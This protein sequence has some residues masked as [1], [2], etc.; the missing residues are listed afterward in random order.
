MEAPLT[1]IIVI[2]GPTASG[3]SGL[4]LLAAQ[5]LKGVIVNADS[6]Q[7]YQGMDIG[8]AK[9]SAAER[10]LAEHRLFDVAAPDEDFDAAR[11][12]ALAADAIK[13]IT[14]RGKL[15][16]VTGG[17]GLYIRA[18]LHGLC[19]APEIPATV[20]EKYRRL[21]N[22]EGAPALHALLAAKDPLMASRLHVNDYVRVSRALEVWEVAGESLAAWQARHGGFGALRYNTLQI[23]VK[24]NREELYARINLRV[25]NM[26]ARGF[27][28][29]VRGLLAKGYHAGLKSMGSIGYKQMAAYIAGQMDYAEMTRLMQ[30]D[31]RHYAKR[32][33]TW[34]LRVKG[35]EWLPPSETERFL[36]LA[37][38]FLNA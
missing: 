18:L 9:P 5:K 22:N 37:Q 25:E 4:A 8:T 20:R 12:A 17:T 14:A 10:A 35:V 16:I 2:C 3:K 30:R 21:Y 31:T 15:P 7:I 36:A 24:L 23:G 26:L 13:D 27:E 1:K 28:N 19:E 38:T 34:F 33:L 29:E 6:M 32:Q 11:Y